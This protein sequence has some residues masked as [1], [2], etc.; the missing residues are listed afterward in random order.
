M[1]NKAASDRPTSLDSAAAV[2]RARLATALPVQHSNPL[3]AGL[4]L[5]LAH[6]L[7]R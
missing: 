4:A 2:I 3:A 1:A 7:L 5:C 6:A